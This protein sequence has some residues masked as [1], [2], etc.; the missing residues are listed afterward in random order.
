MNDR[1]FVTYPDHCL[2]RWR[3]QYLEKSAL[4][5]L[6]SESVKER[7]RPVQPLLQ[8]YKRY[9]QDLDRAFNEEPQLQK[10]EFWNTF[11]PLDQLRSQPVHV[12]DRQLSKA[13]ADYQNK[14]NMALWLGLDP[15][16]KQQLNLLKN[17]IQD[18]NQNPVRRRA[19]L[20]RIQ[21]QL[22]SRVPAAPS[23][24]TPAEL[25]QGA[26]QPPL[27]EQ[28]QPHTQPVTQ[29]GGQ[30]A[31]ISPELLQQL[32]V[33][34]ATFLPFLLRALAPQQEVRATPQDQSLVRNY[35]AQFTPTK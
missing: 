17:L 16:T 9:N 33:L 35:L 14:V 6:D 30:A 34:A 15:E 24:G 27:Q 28:Q 3:Q 10:P 4:F 7:L 29:T 31:L 22:Q 26:Q 5:G 11:V 12:L 18:I 21:R 8:I 20:E 32:L 25:Q 13:L 2:R 1:N 19:Y 23:P